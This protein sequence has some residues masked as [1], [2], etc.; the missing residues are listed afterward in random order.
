MFDVLVAIL[1]MFQF[2][3]KAF[4]ASIYYI[5]KKQDAPL[6]GQGGTINQIDTLELFFYTR[7]A[8]LMTISVA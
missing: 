8:V 1:A 3:L 5:G 4:F 2:L 6:K 7:L